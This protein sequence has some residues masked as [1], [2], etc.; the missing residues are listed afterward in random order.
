MSIDSIFRKKQLWEKLVN[1]FTTFIKTINR[2]KSSDTLLW[3]G[4]YVDFGD[5]KNTVINHDVEKSIVISFSF[6]VNRSRIY[7]QD[8]NIDKQLVNVELSVK[9]KYIKKILISFYDQS[10]VFNI[11][12]R[13]GVKISINGDKKIFEKNKLKIKKFSNNIIPIITEEIKKEKGQ[14][15]FKSEVIDVSKAEDYCKK[16]INQKK[17][18]EG[19]DFYLFRYYRTPF[20]SKSI[21]LNILKKRIKAKNFLKCS[22]GDEKFIKMNNNLIATQIND[23]IRYLNH[24][25]QYDILAIN[26]LKPVRAMANRYYRIQ[27][28]SINEVDS[29]GSN[30]PMIF[31]NMSSQ[32]LKEF[33]QWS[34]EKF[35]IIFSI[36]VL[37]GHISLIIKH[38]IGDNEKTN[39]ADTGFGYSQMLPIVM[40]L[41]MIHKKIKINE[42][43]RT[44]IIEQ[45]ELHLH[46][47]YQAKMI[48][49]FV[50]IVNEAEKNNIN[51]KVIFETH[52]ETII[53][54][55]GT[56]ISEK[57]IKPD[58]VNILFFDKI[59]D[60]TN[61]RNVCFND[62]GLLTEWPIDFFSADEDYNVD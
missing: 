50:S 54:R 12:K 25:I 2:K 43:I 55:L 10:I 4:D 40:S 15:Q 58:K 17:I 7:F 46:P 51:F 24:A 27:N 5:F 19:F 1:S 37:E 29:D 41:W 31:K 18:S 14:F 8:R 16:Q 22:V 49:V 62:K 61:I 44:I 6:L 36:E 60:I 33:E 35:G 47:A 23:I 9:E 48:D 28:I 32:E 42:I 52:S 45:P 3:Y 34:K 56:L 26:Y 39:L 21:I 38:S 53:N 57:F 59:N 13:G 30:L 11:N 20:L